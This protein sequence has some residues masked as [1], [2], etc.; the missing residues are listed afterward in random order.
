M[1]KVLTNNSDRE[2]IKPIL[3][4][5]LWINRL[6]FSLSNEPKSSCLTI[7]CQKSGPAKYRTHADNNFEQICYYGQNKKDRLFNK[8][9]AKRGERNNNSLVFQIDSVINI[10]KK[11]ETKIYKAAQKLKSLVKQ[12]DGKDRSSD[13]QQIRKQLELVDR[14][15]SGSMK[16]MEE[17][18]DFFFNNNASQAKKRK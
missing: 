14:K 9:L 16:K 3:A 11:D 5:D 6:Y 13:R 17:N 10:S 8:F 12:D 1:L 18:L 4:R 2:T 15:Y 7:D